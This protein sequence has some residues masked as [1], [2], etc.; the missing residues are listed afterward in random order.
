MDGDGR[1]RSLA[2]QT[3]MVTMY[4]VVE[5]ASPLL[6]SLRTPKFEIEHRSEPALGRSEIENV[7][8]V[9]EER[10]RSE[11]SNYTIDLRSCPSLPSLPFV[12]SVIPS[13]CQS[14]QRSRSCCE[15]WG[16]WTVGRIRSFHALNCPI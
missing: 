8:T 6:L 14:G 4:N 11:C 3:T 2:L 7:S 16:Q 5:Q 10:E 15:M 9:S 12:C 1:S 13:I